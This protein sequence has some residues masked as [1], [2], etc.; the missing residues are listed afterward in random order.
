MG[1]TITSKLMAAKRPRLIPV[2][3]SVVRQI[4]PSTGQV[5]ADLREALG[6]EALR[7]RIEHATS[8]AP[9]HV[10]LL[11]RLDVALWMRGRTL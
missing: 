11:R 8:T 1:G 9:A 10:S 3:D 2:R 5:W 6:D 4:L 7:T